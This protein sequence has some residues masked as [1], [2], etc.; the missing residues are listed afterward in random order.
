VDNLI[1]KH[2]TCRIIRDFLCSPQCEMDQDE[3]SHFMLEILFYQVLLCVNAGKPKG[4]Q[5]ILQVCYFICI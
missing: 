1:A 4:A 5:T 3:K 2:N